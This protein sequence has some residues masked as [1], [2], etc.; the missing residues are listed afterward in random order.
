M[1]AYPSSLGLVSGANE[2]LDE[3]SE[4]RKLSLENLQI[5]S[6]LRSEMLARG[7][8]APISGVLAK[9]EAEFGMPGESEHQD[10]KKQASHI[11][12][13]ASLKKFTLNRVR[14]AHSAH[15][16]AIR[17]KEQELAPYFPI[18]GDHI[19]LLVKGGESAVKT[20]RKLMDA[21]SEHNAPYSQTIATI[22]YMQ[23]NEKK[24]ETLK[25]NY[26]EHL[27]ERVRKTYGEGARVLKTDL[28]RA[29]SS[30][31]KNRS[32]KVA[33]S[34]AIALF[35]SNELAKAHEE[36]SKELSDYNAILKNN[37]LIPGIRIDLVEG[38]E[39]VKEEVAKAGLGIFNEGDFSLEHGLA[40]EINAHK[41]RNERFL[42]KKCMQKLSEALF[43][44]YAI[45]NSA[46]RKSESPIPSIAA[47]PED[48]QLAILDAGGPIG[49]ISQPSALISEKIS[50]EGKSAG[51]SPREFGIGFACKNSGLG[52]VESM[53]L[54]SATREEIESAIKKVSSIEGGRGSE[55][56]SHLSKKG[57]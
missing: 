44:A 36:P 13:I 20:Y 56:L 4:S 43:K 11:K 29:K 28:V 54:F 16:M 22:E 41:L 30:I 15:T 52:I 53:K 26:S 35:A 31:I 39:N 55:F 51:L 25:I 9:T 3:I 2:L 50:S 21:L 32:S 17:L 8:S 47:I 14:V 57:L 12:Y 5:L 46:E 24:T 49:K 7:F 34:C 23:G 6:E 38:H 18:G 45:T 48:S 10:L 42:G 37:K 1:I 40:R 19:K 33:L 27:S